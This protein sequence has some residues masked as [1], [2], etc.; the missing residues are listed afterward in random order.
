MGA[1]NGRVAVVTGGTSGIGLATAYALGQAGAHVVIAARDAERGETARAA[2]QRSSIRSHYVQCDVRKSASVAA[3]MR[4]T[5]AS[6]GQLDILVNCA[7]VE[8]PIAPLHVYPD[9]SLDDVVATNFAGVVLGMKHALPAL[10]AS[11]NGVIINVASTIGTLLPFPGGV[12]YGGTKAAIV[13]MT[14]A[15][16]AG[17]REQGLRAYAVAPWITDT[18]MIDRLTGGS[19]EAKQQFGALNPSGSIVSPADVAEHV[20]SL[21]IDASVAEN[22]AL[23]PIDQRV[24]VL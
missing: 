18:P 3:L 12:V 23:V 8:G 14:A 1:L 17:Y 16:A 22:G 4:T 24:V 15:V 11:G 7:G 2:L 9:E 6:F 5:I 20:L 21:V 13:S 10:I 19:A